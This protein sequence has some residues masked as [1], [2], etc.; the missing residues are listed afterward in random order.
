MSEQILLPVKWIR[1]E[2]YC[3]ATGECDQV[4]RRRIRDG[5]WAAGLHY[6][7]TGPRSLWINLPEVTRWID[8][9]PHVETL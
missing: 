2:T 8:N 7:R 1:C 9:H 3:T 6:K 4:V 5:I